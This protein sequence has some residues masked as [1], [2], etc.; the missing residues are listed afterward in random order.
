LLPGHFKTLLLA[1]WI[2]G[3]DRR[4]LVLMASG[5]GVSHGLIT[6]IA[7]I[8]GILFSR[9]FA[10]FLEQTGFYLGNAYLLIILGA[11]IYFAS[12]TIKLWKT[13]GTH[14]DSCGCSG[15]S[16]ARKVS[17]KTPFKT[18]MLLGIVPCSGTIGL[19]LIG[20]VLLEKAGSI[21]FTFLMLWSGVLVT[22]VLIALLLSVIPIKSASNK[23]PVWAPYAAAAVLCMFILIWRSIVL[24]QDLAFLS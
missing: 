11:F 21:F 12:V 3:M 13:G 22:M 5:Y 19:M 7:I 14:N 1:N 15:C 16:D 18:G 17:G 20:T 6:G 9:F 4:Q 10:G 8:T 23:L 24:W 2:T